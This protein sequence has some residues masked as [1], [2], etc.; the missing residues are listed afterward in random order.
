MLDLCG[1]LRPEERTLEEQ[2]RTAAI[3]DAMPTFRIVGATESSE[4]KRVCLWD[5]A[6]ALLRKHLPTFRQE[7]GDCVSM[8]GANAVNYLAVTEIS[9]NGDAEQ[10]RP[11]YQ[12]YLYATSRV[13]IGNRR[14]GRGDGSVGAWLAEAVKKYGVLAA[15]EQGVPAYSGQVAKAWG[16]DGPPK[17]FVELARPHILKSVAP[18]RTYEDVRDALANGYPCTVASNRGFTMSPVNDGGRLWGRPSGQWAHQMC[19]IGVDDDR[20]RPGCYIINS[21]GEQAHGQPLAGEP[22][23]GFWVDAEVVNGMVGQG[24]SFAWSQFEGFPKQDM[25]WLLI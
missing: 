14:L 2:E 25:D 13:L 9:K 24:D 23:G 1:W 22:P 5:Y 7:I 12:P 4:G 16:Y 17:Q 3:L 8:G 18:V 20:R 19:F 6:K 21:W 11:A 15:D 10:F